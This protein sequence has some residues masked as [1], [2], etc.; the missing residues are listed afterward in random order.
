[1]RNSSLSG[2]TVFEEYDYLGS[3]YELPNTWFVLNEKNKWIRK[4]FEKFSFGS[5]YDYIFNNLASISSIDGEH[6]NVKNGSP[7]FKNSNVCL[8]EYGLPTELL[9]KGSYI[10]GEKNGYTTTVESDGYVVV[11]VN[12]AFPAPILIF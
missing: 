1:M 12:V 9:A 11:A 5:E 8:S 3:V 6:K 10:R 7:M 2:E 4:D